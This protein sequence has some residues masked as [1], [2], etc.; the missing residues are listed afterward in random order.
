MTDK[1]IVIYQGENG[2]ICVDAR[3]EN[4]TIWLTQKAMA[5]V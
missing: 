3:L 5:E 2:E 1:N 4:D